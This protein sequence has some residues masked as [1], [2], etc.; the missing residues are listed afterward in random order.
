[1]M[2]KILAVPLDKPSVPPRE[3]TGRLRSQL[4]YFTSTTDTPGRPALGEREYWFAADEVAR[5]V[6]EGVFYLVS[7]L[8]TANQTEV[9]LSE[10]QEE[11][12]AWLDKAGVRH[13]RIDD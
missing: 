11:F 3:I 1:M 9:E 4:N 10:E 7:P 6:E 8:D 5:W 2:T 13:V 12:L